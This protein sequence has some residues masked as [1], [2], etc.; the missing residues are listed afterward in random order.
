[1]LIERFLSATRPFVCFFYKFRYRGLPF[2]RILL[3]R[4]QKCLSS[5]QVFIHQWPHCFAQ[6][7]IG[8]IDEKL[9]RLRDRNLRLDGMDA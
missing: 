3:A 8:T 6:L 1:M 9:R 2:R 4:R 5:S 7:A